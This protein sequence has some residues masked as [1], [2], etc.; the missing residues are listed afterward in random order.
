MKR[1]LVTGG[2]GYKGCVLVPKLLNAGYAVTVYDLMLFGS[3]GLA[4]HPNLDIVVG[5]IRDTQSFADAVQGCEYVI[6]MACIS[7]DP[8]FEL[9]PDLSKTIN[10]DCFEP[11]VVASKKAGVR[12]FIYVSSSSVYGVSDAPDVTEEHPLVPLTDYNK[13]KGMCEP[14]LLRHGSA[15]FVPV[16]LRPATVCGYSPRMRFDLTVN[17]LTNHAFNRGVIT[18]FGGAQKRP[19]IHIDDV[20][21]LY[22]RMLEYPEELI[23]GE[24]FNAGYENH[25]V[26]QLAEIAKRIVEREFPEKAPIRVETTTSNDNRSYHVSS[27]KIAAKLGYTPQRSIED[28]V[29]DLCCAFRVGKFDDS[30]TNPEYVNVKTVRQLELR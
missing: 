1:V 20:T 6:H 22:V 10:F 9:D 4:P 14:I 27:R 17:I 5:D 15:D 18:V 12:R 26:A 24:I 25:T 21:E 3:R 11:L 16:I 8:S 19:N 28:A 13:Y 2:A 23:A 7:N 29:R 30:M